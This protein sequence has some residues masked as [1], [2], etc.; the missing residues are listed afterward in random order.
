MNT[1]RFIFA[2]NGCARSSVSDPYWLNTD[3]DQAFEVNTYLYPAFKVNTDQDPNPR[4][5]F[6]NILPNFFCN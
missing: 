3:P 2:Y 4:F 6:T 1:H 5:F